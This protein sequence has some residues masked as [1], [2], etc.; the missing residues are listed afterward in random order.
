MMERRLSVLKICISFEFISS[1]FDYYYF[2][3]K[4]TQFYDISACNYSGNFSCETHFVVFFFFF[5]DNHRGEKNWDK[6]RARF[7][8]KIFST[9]KIKRGIVA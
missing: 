8:G 3:L 9:W 7:E 6:K 1:R 4:A 5:A 2:F